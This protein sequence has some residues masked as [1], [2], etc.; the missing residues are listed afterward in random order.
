[1]MPSTHNDSGGKAEGIHGEAVVLDTNIFLRACALDHFDDASAM[2]ETSKHDRTSNSRHGEKI[3]TPKQCR[4]LICA[5]LLPP[6]KIIISGQQAY[7]I[8]KVSMRMREAGDIKKHNMY[9]LQFVEAFAKEFLRKPAWVQPKD[10]ETQY[11]VLKEAINLASEMEASADTA[12]HNAGKIFLSKNRGLLVYAMPEENKQRYYTRGRT[13]VWND[14]LMCHLAHKNHG[15]VI[16]GDGDFTILGKAYAKVHQVDPTCFLNG[17]NQT[18]EILPFCE[19]LRAAVKQQIAS[20]S[21]TP[22]AIEP[23][24]S[25][26]LCS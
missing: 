22:T 14:W 19:R 9:M 3:L 21:T 26:P 25:L 7:E 18:E 23:S 24:P 6:K 12:I 15:M 5:N 13:F 16:T 2:C 17:A 11:E 1:M 10:L 4:A 8:L 20:R